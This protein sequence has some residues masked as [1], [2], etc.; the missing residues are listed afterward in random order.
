MTAQQLI[1]ELKFEKDLENC[2]AQDV[3][4]ASNIE[5]Y[6]HWNRFYPMFN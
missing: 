4:N 5:T 2:N 3:V 1:D 6:D